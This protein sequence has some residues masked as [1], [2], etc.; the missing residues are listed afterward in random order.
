MPKKFRAEER[1]TICSKWKASNLSREDF[2]RQNNIG[3]STLD[4]W[5]SDERQAPSATADKAIQFVSV[6]KLQIPRSNYLE[7]ILPNGIA[8]KLALQTE[9]V[10]KLIKELL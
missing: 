5:L 9:N 7:M 10:V 1:A 3:L 4:R 8:L 6:E 2:C